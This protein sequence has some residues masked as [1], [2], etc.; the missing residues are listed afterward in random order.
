LTWIFNPPIFL[1][2]LWCRTDI[3]SAFDA[4]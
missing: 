4:R 1:L 3:V 2:Q